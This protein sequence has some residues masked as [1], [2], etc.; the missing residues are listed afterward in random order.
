MLP[1]ETDNVSLTENSSHVQSLPDI[2]PATPTAI[3]TSYSGKSV[4]ELRQAAQGAILGLLPHKIRFAELVNEG[5][6]P[7][8]LKQLYESVGVRTKSPDITQPSTKSLASVGNEMQSPIATT[9]VSGQQEAMDTAAPRTNSSHGQT[10]AEITPSANQTTDSVSHKATET[11]AKGSDGNAGSK[12]PKDRAEY[13][14]MMLAAKANK[15]KPSLPIDQ[16]EPSAVF[17]Q[18]SNGSASLSP[19][20]V[21]ANGTAQSVAATVPAE[22][23]QD[24]M[25]F[26]PT[27]PQTSSQNDSTIRDKPRKGAELTE[28]AKRKIEELKRQALAKAQQQYPVASAA[29]GA[30]PTS[31]PPAVPLASLA[32]DQVPSPNPVTTPETSS[33]SRPNSFGA[34]AIPGLFMTGVH[35]QNNV[36]GSTA[37]SNGDAINK[38]RKQ[39]SASNSNDGSATRSGSQL[40]HSDSEMERVVI[41]FSDDEAIEADPKEMH[42]DVDEQA[43]NFLESLASGDHSLPAR[44]SLLTPSKSFSGISRSFTPPIVALRAKDATL[45]QK[46]KEIQEMHRRIAEM[47]ARA[48]AKQATLSRTSTARQTPEA[49]SAASAHN[50]PPKASRSS[51]VQSRSSPISINSS[52]EAPTRTSSEPMISMPKSLK[53]VRS[54]ES[55]LR[56][57]QRKKEIEDGLPILDAEVKRIEEKLAQA[58][59]EARELEAALL[60]GIEGRKSLV[61]ELEGLDVD[62]EEADGSEEGE[63]KESRLDLTNDADVLSQN[64]RADEQ[65]SVVEDF[66]D[67]PATQQQPERFAEETGRPS[68]PQDISVTSDLTPAQDSLTQT[69]L[70]QIPDASHPPASATA[71]ATITSAQGLTIDAPRMAVPLASPDMAQD[72][73]AN[74]PSDD[75]TDVDMESEGTDSNSEVSMSIENSTMSPIAARGQIP[76]DASDI[77]ELSQRSFEPASEDGAQSEDEEE[78]EPMDSQSNAPATDSE[79]D[80]NDYEPPDADVESADEV[81]SGSSFSPPPVSVRSIDE[82]ELHSN[83]EVEALDELPSL[84]DQGLISGPAETNP[85]C[86]SPS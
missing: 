80:E 62:M 3:V 64:N 82:Q 84:E 41:D 5:I 69:N 29:L 36:A 68:P 71:A 39:P 11:K 31:I 35:A 79:S 19:T 76:G 47:Q 48:K 17:T 21:G 49:S 6:D 63:D 85:V 4:S 77:A 43:S 50:T 22:A 83:D 73:G 2:S 1:A 34:G 33:S 78:Y 45:E 23:P 27:T 8:V 44:P 53:R 24:K 7:S 16:N 40:Y 15:S 65:A 13:I 60:K 10:A 12:K 38:I 58:R 54:E 72:R 51:P 26:P 52:H 59:Q 42:M 56:R 81:A 66:H 74:K 67:L 20:S 70:E 61:V 30:T 75:P 25:S 57:I 28:L 18:G 46:D 14:K 9:S 37:A 32:S 86:P 55:L